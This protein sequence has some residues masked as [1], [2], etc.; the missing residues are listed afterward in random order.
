MA[1]QIVTLRSREN[2]TTPAEVG[3]NPVEII[4]DGGVGELLALFSCASC[5]IYT[6]PAFEISCQRWVP[7]T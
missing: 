5:L 6:D 1:S 7:V 4:R 3:S 2:R